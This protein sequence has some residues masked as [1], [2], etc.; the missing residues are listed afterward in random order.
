MKDDGTVKDEINKTQLK[1]NTNNNSNITFGQVPFDE[2]E[3]TIIRRL[4]ENKLGFS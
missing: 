2:E 1:Q 3:R 4:L